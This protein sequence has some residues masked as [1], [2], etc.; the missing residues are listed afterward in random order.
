MYVWYFCSWYTQHYSAKCFC[1]KCKL[2]STTIYAKLLQNH[3]YPRTHIVPKKVTRQSTANGI[4]PVQKIYLEIPRI[5][6]SL[7]YMSMQIGAWGAT[8]VWRIMHLTTF[9]QS[10]QQRTSMN[11]EKYNTYTCTRSRFWDTQHAM[12]VYVCNSSSVFVRWTPSGVRAP[13]S[14]P[15]PRTRHGF[16]RNYTA[17]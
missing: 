17:T 10:Y 15:C 5:L 7:H 2:F 6:A 16:A 9:D 13:D 8:A 14:F 1:I 11:I 3:I 4:R 12:Y